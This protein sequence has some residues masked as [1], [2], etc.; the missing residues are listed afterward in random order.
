M[1]IQH[2]AIADA[3]R[4]EPKGASTAMAGQTIIAN[5]SGG[6]SFGSYD[7]NNLANKPTLGTAATSDATDFATAAQGAKADAALPKAGGVM[8]GPVQVSLFTLATLPDV[9]T[10]NRYLIVVSDAT[11][12]PA[13]CISN[14]TNWI[15]IR[16]NAAVV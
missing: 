7:Y 13:L 6:T 1:S 15:D 10:Y 9:T 3:D 14:G 8:T 11:S 4:H 2:S 16:T 5:G 12:G